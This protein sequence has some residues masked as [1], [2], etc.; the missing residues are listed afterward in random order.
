[1]AL[2]QIEKMR[3]VTFDYKEGSYSPEDGPHSVGLI[4]EEVEK[5]NPVLVDYGY[6]KKP[7]TLHFERFVGLFVQAIQDVVARVSGL[8]DKLNKQQKQIDA[9]Q[10][11]IDKLM[12]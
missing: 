9:M 8:E 11:Q 2:E 3:A 1:M 5:I 6:D 4:A 7:L 10:K 12:K